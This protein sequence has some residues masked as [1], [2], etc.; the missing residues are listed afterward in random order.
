M[1]QKLSAV[2]MVSFLLLSSFSLRGNDLPS[3]E[4]DSLLEEETRAEDAG[5][6]IP[7]SKKPVDKKMI[8]KQGEDAV[9][10]EVR[11]NFPGV[12]RFQMAGEDGTKKSFSLKTLNQSFQRI[13]SEEELKGNRKVEVGRPAE[14]YPNQI[15]EISS[16]PR[17]YIRP[18]FLRYDNEQEVRKMIPQWE[19]LSD[20]VTHTGRLSFFQTASGVRVDLD[21]R[22][23]KVFPGIRLKSLEIS[24]GK[25][26]FVEARAH[27]NTANT[28]EWEAIP[29][30]GLGH[31]GAMSN[32][33]LSVA[34]GAQRVGQIPLEVVKPAC[35]LDLSTTKAYTRLTQDTI[36]LYLQRSSFERNPESYLTSVPNGFYQNAY[37]LFSL[38]PNPEKVRAFC[39]RMTRFNGL[40]RGD[41]F[42]YTDVTLPPEGEPLPPHIRQVGTTTLNGKTLPLYLGEFP[43]ACGEIEDIINRDPM[44]EQFFCASR[45]DSLEFDLLGP[46]YKGG[47]NIYVNWEHY[48]DDRKK[49]AV[50]VFAL[51]LQRAPVHFEVCVKQPGNLFRAQDVPATGVKLTGIQNKTTFKLSW[52]ISDA[53]G[54]KELGMGSKEISLNAGESREETIPLLEKAPLG[55]YNL[56]IS[57]QEQGKPNPFLTH[58]ESFAILGPD[59]RQ[60]SGKESPFGCWWFLEG[61]HYAPS[62]PAFVLDV[63]NRAGIRRISFMPDL[64]TDYGKRFVE[65]RKKYQIILNQFPW[66][67]KFPEGTEEEVDQKLHEFY[68]KMIA[69]NPDTEY[70]LLFH[71][72]FGG[73]DAPELHGENGKPGEQEWAMKQATAFRKFIRKHYPQLKIVIGNSG[74]PVQCMASLFRDGM[75]PAEFD[76]V[77]IEALGAGV[78]PETLRTGSPASSWCVQEVA[79]HFGYKVAMTGCFEF[80]SR[81]CDVLGVKQHA[82]YLVRDGLVGLA[83]GFR[84]IGLGSLPI[85]DPYCQSIY[86]DTALLTRDL[87]PRPAYTAYAVLTRV[88]DQ[89][90]FNPVLYPTGAATTYAL[91]FAR[92]RGDFACA[93]WTPRNSAEVKVSFDR[94]V[95]IEIVQFFG[96]SKKMRGR[97]FLLEASGT[98]VYFLAPG[99]PASIVHV[100]AL[101]NEDTTGTASLTD[102]PGSDQWRHWDGCQDLNSEDGTRRVPGNIQVST[103]KDPEQGECLEFRLLRNPDDKLSPMAEEYSYFRLKQPIL[104]PGTPDTLAALVKGDGGG[105]ELLFEIQDA[106]G[107]ISRTGGRAGCGSDQLLNFTFQGWNWLYHPLSGLGIR[108]WNRKNLAATAFW[109]GT[110]SL[111]YPVKILGV[112]VGLRRKTLNLRDMVDVPGVIRLKKMGGL[113]HEDQQPLPKKGVQP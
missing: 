20:A 61:V 113:Y 81:R 95:E 75:K 49:S 84:T 104:L 86:G 94:D 76:Y 106:D 79:R 11:M 67:M 51:T 58:R 40:G 28:G 92:K 31:G 57:L 3:L 85:S 33:K 10:V 16:G 27:R 4:S 17:Y 98:P 2:F 19:K 43:V 41:G 8:L 96:A 71:E 52:T 97:E 24:G 101:S 9:T 1:I 7:V 46:R 78:P 63:L 38:D 13:R 70:V 29:L 36:D 23:W 82:E 39:F 45:R 5:A 65:L 56:A 102:V 6:L 55:H 72:S 26:P 59:T 44:P 100:R 66:I 111:K 42:A 50:N 47:K 112:Y 108:G 62:D 53:Y 35:S 54:E 103:V 93:I 105:G 14:S 99:K 88:F 110:S 18:N 37:L 90:D 12:L 25:G 34:T 107:K 68:D 60:A 80:T 77:G 109:T 22:Y 48:P 15:W 87:Y 73:A 74:I 30:T 69:Q 89:I 32:A 91:G 21:G 83:L 64:E